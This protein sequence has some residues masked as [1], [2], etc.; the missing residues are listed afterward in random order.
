M[1]CHNECTQLLDIQDSNWVV[2]FTSKEVV[3]SIVQPAAESTALD[4]IYS[5]H[6]WLNGF[7]DQAILPYG[8]RGTLGF[9]VLA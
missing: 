8:N 3:E 9:N 4:S 7:T 6:S 1:N 2:F 5:R